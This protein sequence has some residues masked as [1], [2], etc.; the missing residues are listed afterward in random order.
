MKVAQ[1]FDDHY[2][3]HGHTYEAH[4]LTLAPAVAAINEMKRMDLVARARTMG[5]YLGKRLHDLKPKH[6]SIGDVRGIGMF[7]AV[8]LVR[9]QKTKQ[10][11]NTKVDKVTGKPL[12][13]DRVAAEMMKNGVFLQA[14]ISHFVVAPP[15]IITK[16]EIDLGMKALD[17]ALK[18]AD[19]EVQH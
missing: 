11:F 19:A 8:E 3:S 5:E 13:V 1:Y 18:I 7:W 15:L 17:E 4:P 9:D 12:L 2:F 16:E 6:P 14:W 10:P